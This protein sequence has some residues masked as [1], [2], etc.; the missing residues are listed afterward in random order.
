MRL[1]GYFHLCLIACQLIFF[2]REA[3]AEE[4]E[5]SQVGWAFGFGSMKPWLET[6]AE[7]LQKYFT[8]HSDWK[9]N[10][11]IR[12]AAFDELRGSMHN[13]SLL[14][15]DEYVSFELAEQGARFQLVN[16]S[17]DLLFYGSLPF[18]HYV[19]WQDGYEVE[20]PFDPD[21]D[22]PE[23]AWR[24]HAAAEDRIRMAAIGGVRRLAELGVLG[25]RDV[26]LEAMH[27][28]RASVRGEATHAFIITAPNRLHAFEIAQ[29]VL[30]QDDRTVFLQRLTLQPEQVSA[31]FE[32]T[33]ASLGE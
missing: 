9:C 14:I 33:D 23:S 3:L 31:M 20:V 22:S 15:E 4:P 6:E 11:A 12:R 2:P 30:S 16:L 18:L 29:S 25:A 13:T 26:L 32:D 8:Q 28:P 10:E 5:E 24:A 19:I 17:A 27:H 21:Y 1:T 7:N